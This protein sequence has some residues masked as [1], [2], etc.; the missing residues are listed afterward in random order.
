[1]I[2]AHLEEILKPYVGCLPCQPLIK[3]IVD[4]HGCQRISD[5][6]A[7]DLLKAA[8]VKYA[9]FNKYHFSEILKTWIASLT[10]SEWWDWSNSMVALLP[11]L[12]NPCQKFKFYTTMC[13]QGNYDNPISLKATYGKSDV[14][15][16]ICVWRCGGCH[17]PL[18]RSPAF[19]LVTDANLVIHVPFPDSWEISSGCRGF[20]KNCD[21]CLC[22]YTSNPSIVGVF[23]EHKTYAGAHCHLCLK[24]KCIDHAF[25][26]FDQAQQQQRG[27]ICNSCV[28]KFASL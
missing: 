26:F 12:L 25:P 1:M 5:W 16:E 17:V 4:Y 3:I 9:G 20:C 28:E 7:R 6:L 19:I 18:V 24:Y 8:H 14:S 23:K 10:L 2:K 22:H 11:I 13:W 27:T 15:T 21:K